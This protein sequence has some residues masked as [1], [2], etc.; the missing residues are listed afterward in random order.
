MSRVRARDIKQDAYP[1]TRATRAPDAG[2]A[3]EEKGLPPDPIPRPADQEWRLTLILRNMRTVGN[4]SIA[5]NPAEPT[6]GP[7]YIYGPSSAT[8]QPHQD[9]CRL[10]GPDHSP[11]A[12]VHGGS[13]KPQPSS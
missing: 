11:A 4:L 3:S 5:A 12:A 8:E 6:I 2:A 9:F 10:A 1:L 7:L 13:E